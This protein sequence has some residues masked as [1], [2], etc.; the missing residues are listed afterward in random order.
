[1]QGFIDECFYPLLM[2]KITEADVD[3]FM[4]GKPYL[5]AEQVKTQLPS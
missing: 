3:K 2:N 5:T 4:Q 1:M